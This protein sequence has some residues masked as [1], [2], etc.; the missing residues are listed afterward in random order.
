MKMTYTVFLNVTEIEDKSL[1]DMEKLGE[2]LEEIARILMEN[3]D[4][5]KSFG[6]VYYEIGIDKEE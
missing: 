1:D 6:Q 4:G 5:V 3:M 2:Q